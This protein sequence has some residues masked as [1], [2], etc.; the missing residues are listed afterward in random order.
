MSE[1]EL[2]PEGEDLE[3]LPSRWNSVPLVAVA[4][5]LCAAQLM[6]T[7]H[8]KGQ[9]M[10]LLRDPH[11]WLPWKNKNPWKN[12]V[13]NWWVNKNQWLNTNPW[14]NKNPWHPVHGQANSVWK[15]AANWKPDATWK[16]SQPWKNPNPWTPPQGGPGAAK[17]L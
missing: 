12:P 9:V 3:A 16:N 8:M 15:K 17:K 10:K 6:G 2:R 13:G 7:R 11:V 5:P 4:I 1:N 14:R